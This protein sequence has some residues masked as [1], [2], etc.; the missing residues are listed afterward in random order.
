[1]LLQE[2]VANADRGVRKSGYSAEHCLS[3]VAKLLE[4][5]IRVRVYKRTWALVPDSALESIFYFSQ[6][7]G[8]VSLRLHGIPGM[9][10]SNLLFILAALDISTSSACCLFPVMLLA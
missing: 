8:V 7:Y 1:M 10:Y 6:T 9:K 5:D 2:L 4:T 3:I